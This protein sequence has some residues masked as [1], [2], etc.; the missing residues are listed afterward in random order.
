MKRKTKVVLDIIFA[1][2]LVTAA[3]SIGRAATITRETISND[4]TC[5]LWSISPTPL[6]RRFPISNFR[7]FRQGAWFCRC[8]SVFLRVRWECVLHAARHYASSWPITCA[9]RRSFLH[10]HDNLRM[11]TSAPCVIAS[12]CATGSGAASEIRCELKDYWTRGKW[13]LKAPFLENTLAPRIRRYGSMTQPH[14]PAQLSPLLWTN[15]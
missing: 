9:Q 6:A 10:E 3:L 12:I 2:G 14:P 1:L 13:A 7:G 15:G 4:V 11:P 8:I 5:K